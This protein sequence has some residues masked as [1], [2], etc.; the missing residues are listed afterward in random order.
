MVYRRPYRRRP[1]RRRPYRRQPYRKRTYR[2][3]RAYKPYVK[4]ISI[5]T[6][7]PDLLRTKVKY[8]ENKILTDAIGGITKTQVYRGNSLYDP[9]Y[10]G[11]GGQPVSYDQWA[12]FYAHYKVNSCKIRVTFLSRT[13]LSANGNILVGIIPSISPTGATSLSAI[14]IIQQPYVK[15]AYITQGDGGK[16]SAVINSYMSTKKMFAVKNTDAEE[17]SAAF[18]TN[19]ADGWYFTVFAVSADES[20][21]INVQCMVEVTYYSEFSERVQ[22][23]QS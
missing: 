12:N 7:I 3:K 6:G 19:P 4:K 10:T 23:F 11:A 22:L 16:N 9:D 21:T 1:Y 15:Y 8:A 17:F 14:E 20:S 18:T 13:N 2:R 5:A